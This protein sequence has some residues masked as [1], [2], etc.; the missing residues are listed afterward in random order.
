MSIKKARVQERKYAVPLAKG[1][2][3]R[4]YEDEFV[5]RWKYVWKRNNSS[6]SIAPPKGGGFRG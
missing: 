1:P 5:L 3:V 4:P 6:K 2:R